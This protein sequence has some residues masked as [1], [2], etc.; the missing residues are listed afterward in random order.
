MV[1]RPGL[2]VR[3]RGEGFGEHIRAV[4]IDV[5]GYGGDDRAALKAPS[6]P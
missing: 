1:G 4:D 3:R 5:E 2:G 6:R